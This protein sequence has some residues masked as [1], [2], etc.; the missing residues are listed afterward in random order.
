MHKQTD[1]RPDVERDER[2]EKPVA[3]QSAPATDLP[4]RHF[5][6]L[7]CL[8]IAAIAVIIVLVTTLPRPGTRS[9]DDMAPGERTV[10]IGQESAQDE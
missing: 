6:L 7:Y 3:G 1:A 9:D 4:L 10:V 2:S 8:A 5:V